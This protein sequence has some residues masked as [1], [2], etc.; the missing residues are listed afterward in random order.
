MTSAHFYKKLQIKMIHVEHTYNIQYIYGRRAFAVAG[1]MAFNAMSDHLRD[2]SV[3]TA[4][5]V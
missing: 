2:P 3:N 4:T 1:A 5:F